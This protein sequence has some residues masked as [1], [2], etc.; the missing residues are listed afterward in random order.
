VAGQ[1]TSLEISTFVA[2]LN[3]EAGPLTF[4]ENASLDEQNFV[5]DVD[6][7]RQRRLGMDWEAD[8][9]S[10]FNSF[11]TKRN[12]FNHVVD[13][14]EWKNAGNRGDIDI[15][16][17]HSG[18]Q[19]FF[20]D[21][22]SKTVSRNLLYIYQL[23]GAEGLERM[24]G[25]SI[26]GRFILSTGT[27]FV[28]LFELEPEGLVITNS[29]RYIAVRDTWGVDD[30]LEVD[31]RPT[32]LTQKHDYNLRNQGWVKSLE[33]F[34][35]RTSGIDL[36]DPVRNLE[37]YQDF[38][39]SNADNIWNGKATT[40]TRA[41]EVGRWSSWDLLK[42]GFGV[43]P[44][45]KGKFVLD[46][47]FARG[48]F[49]NEYIKDRSSYNYSSELPADYTYGEV[50]AVAAYAGRVFYSIK[51]DRSI[52]ADD[53]APNLG[54]MI[55]FSQIAENID[56]INK[57]YSE[58][59]PTAE[60]FNKPLDT[61]GGF[62]NIPEIGRVTGMEP[63]GNSL[64]VFA[65]NGVWEIH[66]GEGSFSSTNQ[67]LSKA[68]NS[69]CSSL[70]SIVKGE[71]ML[72]YWSAGGIYAIELDGVS[73]RGKAVNITKD[74]IQSIFNRIPADARANVTGTYDEASRQVRWLYRTGALVNPYYFDNEL[75][76]DLTLT[77]W[78]RN[79]FPT[80]DTTLK[81]YPAGY[82]PVPFLIFGDKT[83][84][85]TVETVPVTVGGAQV[86]ITTREIDTDVVSSIKYIASF[87]NP[88]DGNAAFSFSQYNN[89]AFLDWGVVDA[90]AYLVTGYWTGQ[91]ASKEKSVLSITTHML[92]TESGF[93]SVDGGDS[94]EVIDPSA[95]LMQA[96][97]A[98]TNSPASGRWGDEQQAYKLKEF[99]T[100][101]AP[102]TQFDYSKTVISTRNTLRGHGE[103]LSLQFRTEPGKGCHIYGWSKEIYVEPSS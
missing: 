37:K 36:T 61:D 72:A 100:P 50:G 52:E 48:L 97:W 18:N 44:T 47:V 94:F 87:T 92:R 16:V 28:T 19:V 91:V 51:Q 9:Q 49:R 88:L 14:F 30:G 46:S 75:V 81:V 10:I 86:D 60:D 73:L 24:Y 22:S 93:N 55:F 45:P 31:K 59:D 6:G 1:R 5:L 53:K 95:C 68:S 85:T 58:N 69:G 62:I 83:E 84:D 38:Y 7:S 11:D 23:S 54:T 74:S 27:T 12:G 82:V 32:S 99:Y 26:Y 13:S 29:R 80:L 76:F 25:T 8:R 57:C 79:K 17:V 39:P 34:T 77:A 101:N 56:S 33:C 63:L 3:T 103:A 42:V 64:F 98:W 96:Q 102:S 41:E 67:N 4:P 43:T 20:F 40:A 21:T 15:V 35:E 2:G 65:T 70:G 71:G 89:S 90:S 66:G 78:Y